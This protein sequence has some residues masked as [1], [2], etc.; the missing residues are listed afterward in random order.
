MSCSRP[1]W[2]WTVVTWTM[3]CGADKSEGLQYP[4]ADFHGLTHDAGWVWRTDGIGSVDTG[5]GN[6]LDEAALVWGRHDGEGVVELRQGARFGTAE[7][8]GSLRFQVPVDDLVL[9]AWDLPTV[10][11]GRMTGEGRLRLADADA[12]DGDVHAT[13]DLRCVTRVN[14]GA[15]TFFGSFE[16]TLTLV[17]SG[18]A[19]RPSGRWTFA[20]GVGLVQLQADVIASLD[21]VRP[22]R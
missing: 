17:C 15:H 13:D 5:R 18:P 11:G 6:A 1:L 2:T 16:D 8:Y 4:I 10:D 20:R 19:D 14:Q 22:G 21:L 7:A 3:G 9:R 12:A